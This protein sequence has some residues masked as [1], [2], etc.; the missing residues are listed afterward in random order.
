METIRKESIK[1]QDPR[2]LVMN[3]SILDTGSSILFISKIKN[4]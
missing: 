4:I 2:I 3:N 1:L